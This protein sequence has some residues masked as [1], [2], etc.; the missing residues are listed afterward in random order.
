VVVVDWDCDDLAAAG[1]IV[2]IVELRYIGMPQCLS[3]ADALVGVELQAA[4]N[5]S[6]D[7]VGCMRSLACRG[8]CNCVPFCYSAAAVHSVGTAAEA[9]ASK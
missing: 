7:I 5:S 9:T 6:Q 2:W 8:G 1:F 3:S 4:H